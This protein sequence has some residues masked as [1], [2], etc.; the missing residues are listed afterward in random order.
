MSIFRREKTNF[1]RKAKKRKLLLSCIKKQMD[2]Y[3]S[4]ISNFK[5]A[6]FK[7]F[8]FI[9]RFFNINFYKAMFTLIQHNKLSQGTKANIKN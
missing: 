1:F 3:C 8:H 7:Q 9:S 6:C 2:Y 5:F 4:A